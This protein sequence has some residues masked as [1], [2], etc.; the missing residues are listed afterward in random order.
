MAL[1]PLANEDELLEEI[2]KGDGRAFTVL[3]NHYQKFIFSFARS[4]SRDEQLAIDITQEA[5]LKVWTQR[6]KLSQIENFPAYLNRLVRNHTFNT[7]R[8]LKRQPTVDF[9]LDLLKDIAEDSTQGQLDYNET[10]GI[11]NQAIST[12]S[13]QQQIAFKLCH[14][15]GLKYSEAAEAMNLSPQTVNV[16]MKHALKKIREHLLKHSITYHLIA[17]SLLKK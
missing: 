11:L 4:L 12:L 2:A 8:D 13:E 6:E 15:Q 16:H 14:Q 1:I 3:F 10:L 9:E 7:L 5:F 17:L